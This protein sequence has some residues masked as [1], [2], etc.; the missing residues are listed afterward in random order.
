MPNPILTRAI[1]ALASSRDLSVEESAEVLAEIMHGDVSEIQIAAFLIALRTK[2]ETVEELAGLARTMR[3]LAAHVPSDRAGSAGHR[4]HGGRAQHLQRLD[5]RGADRGRGGLRGGQ[6]R[7]P[8]GHQQIGLG[9]SARGAGR[10]DRPR[11][12]GGGGAASRRRASASCSRRPTTRRRASWCPVRRELAVRTIFNLLGPLTNP[13]GARRQLIGV[14]DASFLERMAGA[15]ATLGVDPR[16]GRRGEDGLD[17]VSS[18]RADQSRRGE[19]RGDHALHA[20]PAEVG[21]DAPAR[22]RASC[23]GGRPQENA[24]VTRAILEARASGAGPARRASPLINAGA[25]IYVAGAGADDRRG[26]RSAPRG[27]RRRTGR[28]RA[29]ALSSRPASRAS[30]PAGGWRADEHSRAATVLDRILARNARGGRAA[31]ARAAAGADALPPAPAAAAGERRFRD[32]L[33]RRA[34]A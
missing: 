3:A 2:G 11:P 16:A 17:E 25:A 13:A 8:L 7:Q 23:D 29:R 31:Q 34:S 18:A 24:A 1:D 22:R 21:I 27:D 9:R 5:H 28:A 26:R 32:A 10:P 12:A 14:S 20:R 6:A 19:R 33:Q 30:A 4:R 15:L